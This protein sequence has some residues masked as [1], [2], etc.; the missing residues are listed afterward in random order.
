VLRTFLLATLIV[1]LL[2]ILLGA[3]LRNLAAGG[4]VTA[5]LVGLLVGWGRL[6]S[7]VG[8]YLRQSLAIKVVGALVAIA[9]VAIAAWLLWRFVSRPSGWGRVTQALN[10]LGVLFLAVTLFG[11]ARSGVLGF[12]WSDLTTRASSSTPA[13]GSADPDIWVIMPDEYG[14]ADVLQSVYGIDM[15]PFLEGLRQRGFEVAQG[16]SS[17]Y[18]A[19]PYNLMAMLHMRQVPEIPSM[20]PVLSGDIDLQAGMRNGVNHNETFDLLRARG[21]EIVTVAPPWE[22]VALRSADRYIDNGGIN[23]FETSLVERTALHPVVRALLPDVLFQQERDRVTFAFDEIG[24]L[25]AERSDRP[26][27][28]FVHLV[29]PHFPT[30]FGAEGEHTTMP[31]G[32]FFWVQSAPQRGITRDEFIAAYKGQLEYLNTLLPPALDEIVQADPN[33]VVLF[34]S[35]EGTGVGMDWEDVPS[36]DLAERFVGHFSARTPGK[37]GVFAPLK[38]IV[39]TMPLL[40]NAYFGAGLPMQPD[41]HYA[42]RDAHE[43]DLYEWEGNLP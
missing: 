42:W 30:V 34:M 16:N 3:A 17:N 33:A 40:F 5:L 27:F 28:I 22:D 26:R 19:T 4:L 24:R 6:E 41:T 38:T 21:Y 9:V 2:T 14:R 18:L 32:E 7:Y 12:A 8:S 13:S 11:A 1:A 20:A 39:N 31:Y 15:A 43:I 37:T 10:V 29:A 35:D 23:E 25:A 36:S